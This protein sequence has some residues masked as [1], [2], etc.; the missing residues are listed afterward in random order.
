LLQI[1]SEKVILT[2]AGGGY[3]W[4]ENSIGKPIGYQQA[5]STAKEKKS[6]II[7]TR[8]RPTCIIITWGRIA[9]TIPF[10]LP[11]PLPTSTSSA[12]PMIGLP[13]ACPYG[14]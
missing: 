7:T 1:P 2:I 11:M 3:D 8:N 9:L 6:K 10:I 14:V 5:I 13:A 12:W 4:P